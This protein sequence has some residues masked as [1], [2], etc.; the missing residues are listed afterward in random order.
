MK[1]DGDRYRLLYEAELESRNL[2]VVY[3]GNTNSSAG[4][5][6]DNSKRVILLA[7]RAIRIE[8]S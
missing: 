1:K 8:V 4:G 2:I 3:D 5:H 7:Q 6:S